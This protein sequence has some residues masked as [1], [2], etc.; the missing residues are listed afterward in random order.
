MGSLRGG[1]ARHHAVAKIG[2]A[3]HHEGR[4]MRSTPN[5][6][7]LVGRILAAALTAPFVAALAAL[8]AGGGG[9]C[10]VGDQNCND[11]TIDTD[12][13]DPCPYGPPGGPQKPGDSCPSIDPLPAEECDGVSFEGVFGLL[14]GPPGNCGN[15]ACHG[16]QAAAATAS[17]VLLDPDDPVAF[18]TQLAEYTNPRGDPYAAEGA[19]RAWILCNLKALPGGGS[20][21]PKPSGL[22]PFPDE[23]AEV[24]RWVRCGMKPPGGGASS[25]TSGGGGGGGDQGGGG[26]G[27]GGAGGGGTGGGGGAGGAGGG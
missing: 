19:Q 1:S 22:G 7:P 12:L 13:D 5:R 25:T 18:Y 8:V 16:T 14:A 17:G 21:M 15:A 20:P 6:R 27:E 9:G 11:D 26:A 2:V 10:S 24:E 4:R 23:L 3:L